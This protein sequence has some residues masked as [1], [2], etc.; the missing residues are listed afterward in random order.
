VSALRNRIVLSR[1]IMVAPSLTVTVCISYGNR[2]PAHRGTALTNRPGMWSSLPSTFTAGVSRLTSAYRVLLPSRRDPCLR[3][4]RN[5]WADQYRVSRA[6]PFRHKVLGK[7][8]GWGNHAPK[9]G[10]PPTPSPH[11]IHPA[12]SAESK[13]VASGPD[14]R[15]TGR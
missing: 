15:I 4:G 14:T 8:Y 12:K 10:V 2:R 5:S 9:C 1:E 11:N 13:G 7:A 6:I 3:S